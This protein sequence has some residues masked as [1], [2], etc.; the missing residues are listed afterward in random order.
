[1]ILYDEKVKKIIKKLKK[2]AELDGCSLGDYCHNLCSLSEYRFDDMSDEFE[3]SIIKEL[4]MLLDN[5]E[6]NTVIT[7]REVTDVYY[8]E[9]LEWI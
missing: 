3:Q 2:Y 9:E 1:M 4:I 6:N 7:K 8:I 5:F